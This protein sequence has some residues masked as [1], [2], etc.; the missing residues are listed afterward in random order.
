VRAP[1]RPQ[2]FFES[3]WRAT[4]LYLALTLATTWPLAAHIATG[5]PGDLGDSLLNCWILSWSA[6]HVLAWLGGHFDAFRNYW[7]APIFHPAPLAL[8]YSEHLFAQAVQIAPIY[9]LTGNI[10]LCY[11]LL[12][13]STFVLSGLGTYLLV[14]ELT[15]DAI[16][17]WVAGACY[18]FA[19][20]RLPHY[21]H[22]QVLSSQW[23]PFAL[24]GLRRFFVTRRPRPLA[25]AMLA[26]IAQNLSC[27][28]YLIFF[29]PFVA[30]YCLYEMSQRGRW[31]SFD[32]WLALG[33]SAAVT[34]LATWPF[35]KPYLILRALGFPPRALTDVIGYS[36]D[37]LGFVT[38]TTA[39]RVWG[40]LQTFVR[41]EGEVFPGLV[42]PL[43]AL[44]GLAAHFSTWARSTRALQAEAR[45]RRVVP[46]VLLALAA[47]VTAFVLLV[48]ATRDP[49]WRVAGVMV[50]LHKPWQAWTIV[51]ALIVAAL[52]I[53]PRLRAA[54]RAVRGSALAFFTCTAVLSALLSMGPV[55][56]LKGRVTLLPAPYAPLYWYVPGFDGLR[57]PARYAMLTAF[58]LAVVAGYGARALAS[59][60]RRGRVVLAVATTFFLVE[61]TGTPVAIDQAFGSPGYGAPPG[62]VYVGHKVPGIYQAAA[63]LP[64]GSVLLE[65]PFGPRGWELQ[66]VFYQQVHHLPIVNGYSGGFPEWYFA[67][68]ETF[69]HILDKPDA[70]WT[71]L[72]RTG[73]SHVI[74]HRQAY[75]DAGNTLMHRWLVDHGATPVRTVGD[76]WLYVLPAL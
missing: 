75:R 34:M 61:S 47:C 70:A 64:P 68:E 53:S 17:A 16:A 37:V 25:S 23:L 3:G 35:L 31:R 60:G 11:N 30:L 63:M 9:A 52:T 32:V 66:Y 10:I 20:F 50:R 58:A 19:L 45:W 40:G 14:R 36:A 59:H 39:N 15:G 55:V 1:D 73:A 22:L 4:G 7:Q 27:G 2:A 12:F 24:Y 48:G 5:L 72:R 21:V 41:A 69:R 18:A 38:T 56:T 71:T 67:T 6:D 65:F 42:V 76:D 62:H 46:V 13:L 28:Y 26:I 29:T 49:S 74:V 33:V 8:A 57:V 51:G 44:V 43:L 54:A